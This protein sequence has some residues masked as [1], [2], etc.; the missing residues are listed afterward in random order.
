MTRGIPLSVLPITPDGERKKEKSY[1]TDRLK[2]EAK[3]KMQQRT[4][5]DGWIDFPLPKNVWLGRGRPFQ[6]YPGIQSLA[7]MVE[8]HLEQYL[9]HK[10][11]N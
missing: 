8:V 2:K 4:S 6:D 5:S 7:K 11:T 9:C 3:W 1:V 10:V